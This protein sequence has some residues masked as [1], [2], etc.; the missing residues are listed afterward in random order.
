MKKYIYIASFLL[1][2][3]GLTI[4]LGSCRKKGE[5]IAKITVRDT[6]NFVVPGARVILYGTSTTT[7][8]QPVIRRDTAI[9]DSSGV[10]Y[11][12]FDKVYQLGQAGVAVLNIEAKKDG[13]YGESII[14]IVEEEENKALVLIQP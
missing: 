6:G 5:T 3:F 14:K 12:N 1:F 4:S 8:V 11:F 9:T 7:P 2:A 13:L 10:A